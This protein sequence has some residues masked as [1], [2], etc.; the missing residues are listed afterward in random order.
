MFC[1]DC[2]VLCWQPVL[3]ATPNASVPVCFGGR[4]CWRMSIPWCQVLPCAEFL[5]NNLS[6]LLIPL[7]WVTPHFRVRLT[8]VYLHCKLQGDGWAI[9]S[10][11]TPVSFLPSSTVSILAPEPSAA[12]N[13]ADCRSRGIKNPA[14]HGRAT[15][16]GSPERSLCVYWDVWMFTEVVNVLLLIKKF[17]FKSKTIKFGTLSDP[18]F[19]MAIL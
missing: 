9:W 12:W 17:L 13:V 6:Q 18:D 5:T 4:W 10:D 2:S 1:K 14:V 16:G 15:A 19:M 8:A 3:E 7:H 11:T